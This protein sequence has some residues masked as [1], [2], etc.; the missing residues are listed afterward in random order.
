MNVDP[1]EA[2]EAAHAQAVRDSGKADKQALRCAITAAL[3]ADRKRSLSY[4][5]TRFRQRWLLWVGGWEEPNCGGWR[6]KRSYGWASPAPVTVLRAFTYYGWGIDLRLP[7]TNLVW[8]WRGDRG[9]YLSKD[10]TPGRATWWLRKPAWM[11]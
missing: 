10:G 8:C 9:I 5:I 3:V 6:L 1:Y 2:A 4:W 11:R 7:W